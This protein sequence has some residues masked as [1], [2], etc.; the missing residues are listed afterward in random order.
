MGSRDMKKWETSIS[1]IVSEGDEEDVIIRGRRLSDLIGEVT[2]SEMMFL[3]IKGELPSKGQAKVLDAL[4]VASMEHGIA[5][6]S[7]M[8]RCLASYGSPIQAAIAGGVLAF[9][10]YTGGAG[11]QF[12]RMMVDSVE[13]LKEK[14]ADIDQETLRDEAKRIVS[15]SLKSGR[16][17]AGFGIPLH[18]EDPRTPILLKIAREEGVFGTYCR[19]AQLIEEELGKS[20]GKPIPMN[21]DGVGGAIIL[22]L[23]FSWESAR[24][25]IITPRTVSMG[26]HYL[27]EL[28][29]ETRWRHIPQDQVEYTPGKP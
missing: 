27:E 4:L 6:P 18:G 20:F 5:P 19:F 15:D 2:F 16:R 1:Q 26:A 25:F 29:Q 3:L 22:D 9:G 10:D 23:G 7:M 8:S 13:K 14:Q 21:L 28:G 12:A 11:E 24:M 17:V